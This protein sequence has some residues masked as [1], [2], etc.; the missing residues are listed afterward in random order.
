L[1][2]NKIIKISHFLKKKYLNFVAKIK[3]IVF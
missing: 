1:D 2:L 3:A